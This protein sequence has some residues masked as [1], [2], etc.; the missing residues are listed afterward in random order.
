MLAQAVDSWAE[1]GLRVAEARRSAGLTQGALGAE[2]GIDRTAVAKIERGKRTV[3]S[4]ELA[5]LARVLGRAIE[6]FVTEPLPAIVSHRAEMADESEIGEA[7]AVLSRLA[8]DVQLLRDVVGLEAPTSL[9]L[10]RPWTHEEAEQAAHDVRTSLGN[11]TGGP[12]L[13]LD[14][15]SERL[16]L[17]AFSLVLDTGG[18]D[19]AYLPLDEEGVAV[20]NGGHPPARRRFTLAHELGHHVFQDAYI[21]DF[22][23]GDTTEAGERL[24][25]SFAA[26]LL[27]PR[28]SVGDRWSELGGE[29]DPFVAMIYITAEYGVSWTAAC[30][31]LCNIG[32]ISPGLQSTLRAELPTRADYLEHG[33]ATVVELEP[34]SVPPAYAAAVVRAYRSYRIGGSRAIELLHGTLSADELPVTDEYP[35]EALLGELT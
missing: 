10:E 3:S 14:E 2:L 28:S 11:P 29:D 20:V 23:L 9:V 19:G 5:E 32:L 24:I 8:T 34:P 6:W 18:L 25:N 4:L 12:L 1:V 22:V 7:D 17:Y 16:G 13:R 27:M 21:I 26:H 33:I 15:L 30:G 31:H 35:P